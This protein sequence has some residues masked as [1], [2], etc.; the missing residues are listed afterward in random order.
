MQ[1]GDTVY[2]LWDYN[3]SKATVESVGPKKVKLNA[4]SHWV[5][6]IMRIAK[7]KVAM[8]D[9]EVAV[10]WETWKGVRG[11]GYRLEKE[12]Y[13]EHRIRADKVHY[14]CIGGNKNG[15]LTEDEYGVLRG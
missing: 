9:E 15:R 5:R 13:P 2:F 4:G 12:L 11:N 14:Q 3:W 7:E 10:I 1:K 8:P 6:P